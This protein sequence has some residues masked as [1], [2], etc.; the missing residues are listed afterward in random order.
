MESFL[1]SCLRLISS[2]MGS[3]D[4]HS[5]SP[6]FTL[7][8]HIIWTPDINY[9]RGHPGHKWAGWFTLCLLYSIDFPRSDYMSLGL[10]SFPVIAR[11]DYTGSHTASPTQYKWNIE[12]E[13][14]WLLYNLGSLRNG[15]STAFLAVLWA[16]RLSH[17]I[18]RNL[19]CGG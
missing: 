5:S 13:R 19:R 6:S 7:A 12:R 15:T 2:L 10:E 8:V 9:T 11:H 18:L 1:L 14:T 3:L 17:V 16:A 4:Q